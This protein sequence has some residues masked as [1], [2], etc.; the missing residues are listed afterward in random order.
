MARVY[1]SAAAASGSNFFDSV[2]D[3]VQKTLK[4]SED[5]KKESIAKNREVVK[6]LILKAASKGEITVSVAHLCDE[7]SR[8]LVQAGFTVS[9]ASYNDGYHVSYYTIGFAQMQPTS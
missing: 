4:V 6:E 7:V 8:E 5:Q 2:A 3:E 1:T 9:H